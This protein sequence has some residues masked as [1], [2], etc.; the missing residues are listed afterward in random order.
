MSSPP[1]PHNTL[2]LDSGVPHPRW[3][4]DLPRKLRVEMSGDFTGP[5]ELIA[6]LREIADSLEGK[7]V[8]LAPLR[9]A[10]CPFAF[11]AEETS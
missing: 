10:N 9:A 8:N 4:T 11:L 5:A 6:V 3:A 1:I 2:K 7:P